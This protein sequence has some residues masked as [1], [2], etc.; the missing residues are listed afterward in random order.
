MHYELILSATGSCEFQHFYPA[1]TK[2]VYNF[3][4]IIIKKII[5]P[6]EWG[7]SPLKEMDYIHPEQ[8]VAKTPEEKL[9]G[10]EILGAINNKIVGY[11]DIATLEPQMMEDHSPFKQITRKLQMKKGLF[12][13]SETI[14][15]FMEEVKKDLMK[16]LDIN[17]KDDIF[18]ASASHINEEDDATRP[19]GE[20]QDVDSSEEIDLDALFQKFQQQV[21]ESFQHIYSC[22]RKSQR[23]KALQTK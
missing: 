10:Q 23:M 18:M 22:Q 13:K 15:L 17:I 2:K 21:E 1:N 11:L 5:A 19:A 9:H 16:N 8:K 12:S 6:E 14:A 20:G 7:M 3:S 4:K